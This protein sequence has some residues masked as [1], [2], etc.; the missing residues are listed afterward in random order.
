MLDYHGLAAVKA[1]NQTAVAGRHG[2]STR[3]L[4]SWSMALTSAG[5]RLPLS[6]DVAT[7][8]ARRSRPDEDHLARARIARTLGLAIPQ[9]A[10]APHAPVR[11]SQADR[12]AAAIAVR[13]LASAGPLPLDALLSAVRRARRFDTLPIVTAVQLSIA[14]TEAGASHDQGTWQAPRD[15]TAAARDR[16]LVSIVAGRQLARQEMIDAL[17]AAGYT[18]TS[19]RAN[20]ISTHP[21]IRRLGPDRY[22]VIGGSPS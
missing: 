13:V 5:R 10:I 21:L 18:A 17:I 8:V 1:E 4:T 22:R 2:I 9:P 3:T 14:L 6:A 7:E 11:L 19:A 20:Q 15:A 16:A 12:A